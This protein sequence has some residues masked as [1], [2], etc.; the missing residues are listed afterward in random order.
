MA[1][2]MRMPALGQTTDELRIVSWLKREGESVKMGEPLLE[3]ETDK[4]VL[5]VE[6]AYSG[7]VLK[8]LYP[9]D[10]TLEVGTVIAYVGQPGESVGA[11][12]GGAAP[13]ATTAASNDANGAHAP[14]QEAAPAP[15]VAPSGGPMLASPVARQM[16]REHGIDLAGVRGSGPGGRIERK[17]VEVLIGAAAPA[18]PAAAPATATAAQAGDA[19][20]DVPRHRQVIAQRLT[21]SVQTIPQIALMASVDMT[22][23]KATLDAQRAAGLSGLTYTH[24]ILRAVARALRA[25]PNVNTLWRAEGPK[26]WSLAQANV[27]LAVADEDTLLVATIAEP[28]QQE[29]ARTRP[30]RDG[31]DAARAQQRAL[32]GGYRPGGD[33]GEQPRHASRGRLR[34]D[35]RSRSDGDPG[36]RARGR[37]GGGHQRRRPRR[38]PGDADADR[39]S[40]RGRWRRR[41]GSSWRRFARTWSAA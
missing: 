25:H 14:M 30:G 11:S 35:R 6:S 20:R 5:T 41:R 27:G 21:R 17:D 8:I 13:H 24:L 39:R 31:R 38:P 10:E 2:E 9:A 7:T 29:L 26:L 34:G 23:A 1:H 18:A 32:A 16:A 3:V 40:S 36:G 37:R 22:Q 33:H 15:V 28:D 19:E 12:N 4:A